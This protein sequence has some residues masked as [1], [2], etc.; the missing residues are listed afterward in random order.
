MHQGR[1]AYRFAMQVL[2]GIVAF[3]GENRVRMAPPRE[4]ARSPTEGVRLAPSTTPSPFLRT[5]LLK[6]SITSSTW[7]STASQQIGFNSSNKDVNPLPD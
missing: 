1:P 6:R 5:T 7:V 2:E 4:A 3:E